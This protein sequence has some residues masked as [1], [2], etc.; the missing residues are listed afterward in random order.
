MHTEVSQR[1]PTLPSCAAT[2]LWAVTSR[3]EKNWIE[4]MKTWRAISCAASVAVPI[5]LTM[6]VPYRITP[7]VLTLRKDTARP[8]CVQSISCHKCANVNVPGG[9]SEHEVDRTLS[10]VPCRAVHGWK[11]IVP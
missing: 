4:K 2:R 6:V 9:M 3:Q 5:V 8:A 1:Y 11:G 10:C 7:I